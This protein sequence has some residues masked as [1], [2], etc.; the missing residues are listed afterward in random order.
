MNVSELVLSSSGTAWKRGSVDDGEAR[1]VL[2]E[3]VGLRH[4]EHVAREDRVPGALGDH[5][6]RHAIFG[7]GSDEHVLHEHVAPAEISEH[8]TPDAVIA[9][10]LERPVHLP[11]PDVLLARRLLDH[12]LVVRGAPGV[13]AR[14]HHERPFRGDQALV[15]ADRLLVERRRGQVPVR[16]FDVLDPVLVQTVVA[17]RAVVHRALL[18]FGA[19]SEQSPEILSREGR[20]F[21]SG[22]GGRGLFHSASPLGIFTPLP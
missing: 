2:G 3:L 4:E 22:F 7:I 19:I 5:P 16:A 20:Q 11:P 9:S 13:V 15:T 10:R 18:R 14:T 1:L 6:D 12:E 21:N 17:S 8:A